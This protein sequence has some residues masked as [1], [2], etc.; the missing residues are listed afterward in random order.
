MSKKKF[1]VTILIPVFNS[2]N[3]LEKT[4]DCAI[5]QTYK[6]KEI[7]ISDNASTDNVDRIYKKKKYKK[8]KII[9]QKFNIGGIKN[10]NYLI[11]KSKSKYFMILHSDDIISKNYI[12]ECMDMMISDKKASIAVGKIYFDG[13]CFADRN[14]LNLENKKKRL[15]NFF[16][17]YYLD[18]YINGLIKKKF[19]KKFNLNF[20]SPEIPFLAELISNGKILT[21]NT[22]FYKKKGSLNGRPIKERYKWYFLNKSFISRY[23]YF[24][25]CI[26]II[27]KK[28]NLFQ[29]IN[30]FLIFLLYNLPLFK[31][32][33]IKSKL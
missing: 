15:V 3:S 4:L 8:V 26:K 6:N 7:L 11:S 32:I 13:Q 1:L 33:F 25:E 22:C 16:T 12:E 2:I 31:K 29:S 24:F 23:G 5:K 21:C 30:V 17:H 28:L 10:Y 27:F 20:I 18:P 19:V 9:K 14:K